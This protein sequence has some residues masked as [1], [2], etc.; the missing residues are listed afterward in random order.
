MNG[1]K[2]KEWKANEKPRVVIYKPEDSRGRFRSHASTST[3]T[4]VSSSV[5]KSTVCIGLPTPVVNITGIKGY[6]RDGSGASPSHTISVSSESTRPSRIAHKGNTIVEYN[7]Y[8]TSATTSALIDTI[9][10]SLNRHDVNYLLNPSSAS[11]HGKIDDIDIQGRESPKSLFRSSR[12]GAP[13][14]KPYNPDRLLSLA[15][16]QPASFCLNFREIEDDVNHEQAKRLGETELEIPK[17]EKCQ[18]PSFE[19]DSNFLGGTLTAPN[20]L[21]PRGYY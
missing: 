20:S 4:H 17:N 10:N 3:Y 11:T 16:R 6:G 2:R 1:S 18:V 21:L 5:T 9:P 14:T 19:A 15:I 12:A 8:Y 13:L 7:N